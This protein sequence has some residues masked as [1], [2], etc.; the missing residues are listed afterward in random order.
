MKECLL[1]HNFYFTNVT[2][3]GKKA[4]SD[5]G[6]IIVSCQ[7]GLPRCQCVNEVLSSYT[8]VNVDSAS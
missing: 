8:A 2:R 5:L 4:I 3:T 6:G 7:K 1:I